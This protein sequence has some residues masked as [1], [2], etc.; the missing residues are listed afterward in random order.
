MQI[1]LNLKD[2]QP[3]GESIL[4]KFKFIHINIYA[5]VTFKP[6]IGRT[7]FLESSTE[8]NPR[9]TGIGRL[10]ADDT[11]IDF[12]SWEM[13]SIYWAMG[14]VSVWVEVYITTVLH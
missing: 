2:S 3:R 5:L 12:T 9:D 6:M 13:F 11:K 10:G 7:Y 1:F 8:K 4:I 14:W